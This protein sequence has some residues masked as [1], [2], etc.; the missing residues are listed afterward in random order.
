MTPAGLPVTPRPAWALVLF[1][2]IAYGAL[3]AVAVIWLSDWGQNGP[4]FSAG[5]GAAQRQAIGLALVCGAA[6]WWLRDDLL[7]ALL[8]RLAAAASQRPTQRW[9][10][11]LA[12]LL[13]AVLAIGALHWGHKLQALPGLPGGLQPWAA[14]A[15]RWA[16]AQGGL[17]VRASLTVELLRLP[18]CV[19]LAWC[20]YRWRHAGLP[21]VGNLLLALAVALA[22][23]GGLWVSEDKGPMLVIAIAAAFLCAGTVASLLAKLPRGRWLAVAL[24]LGLATAGMA[25]LLLALPHLAPAD[26]VAAWR[27][28]FGG[29]LEYLAQITWVLAGRRAGRLRPGPHAL[30]RPCRRRAGPLPGR[31]HR[32]PE[33]LHPGRVGRFVGPAGS[34]GVGSAVCAVAVVAAAAGGAGAAPAAWH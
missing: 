8:R 25:L 18:A 19:L 33:R 30:V 20:L 13:G 34:A 23:G 12:L 3:C 17:P 5:Y 22:L 1:C 24:G 28:P 14:A 9:G 16:V 21:W 29:R 7:H 6:L 4:G 32:D 10:R 15:S 31:A 2:L 11:V 27:Q 26:R